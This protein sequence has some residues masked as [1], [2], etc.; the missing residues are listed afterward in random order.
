MN[1]FTINLKQRYYFPDGGILNDVV[2]VEELIWHKRE[3]PL[4]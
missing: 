1:R 3:L 4:A 2:D